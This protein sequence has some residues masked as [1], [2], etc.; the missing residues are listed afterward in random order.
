[1]VCK[2]EQPTELIKEAGF[3]EPE[4]YAHL[5]EIQQDVA[6]VP[7]KKPQSKSKRVIYAGHHN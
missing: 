4:V 6:K 7:D 3:D 1:M 5:E 2:K